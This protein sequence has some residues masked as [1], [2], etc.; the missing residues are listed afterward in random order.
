MLISGLLAGFVDAL[1]QQAEIKKA[2]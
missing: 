2:K 1:G